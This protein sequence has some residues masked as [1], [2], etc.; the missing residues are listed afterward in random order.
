MHTVDEDTQYIDISEPKVYDKYIVCRVIMDEGV[1]R[2]RNLVTVKNRAIDD[3]GHALGTAHNNP[4]LDTRQY[5]VELEDR[6]MDRI[7][8]NKI[9]ANIYS[10]VDDGGREVTAFWEIVDHEMNDEAE[11]S[12]QLGTKTTKG[13]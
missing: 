10:Q 11:T 7:F 13:W 12:D 2:G 3:R 4:M 8:A 5:N 6:T 9:P 1:N